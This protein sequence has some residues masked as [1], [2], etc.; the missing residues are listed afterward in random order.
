MREDQLAARDVILDLAKHYNVRY[1]PTPADDVAMVATRL[2]GD[3]V[4]PDAIEDLVV[5]MKRAGVISGPQMVALLGRYLAGTS[6]EQLSRSPE[7]DA[8]VGDVSQ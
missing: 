8:V 3:D 7:D 2:A 6:C 1:H 5:A 4:A